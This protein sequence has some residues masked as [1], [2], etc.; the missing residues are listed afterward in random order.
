MPKI[1][2][3]DMTIAYEQKGNGPPL[4]LLHGALS[5]SRTWHH[6]IET[7]SKKIYRLGMGRSRLWQIHRSTRNISFLR[8]SNPLFV[9][10]SPITL[11]RFPTV[12]SA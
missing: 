2:F 4:V 10:R 12:N 6:Q 7:F 11:V 3:A 8:G 5:D 1:K 9:G